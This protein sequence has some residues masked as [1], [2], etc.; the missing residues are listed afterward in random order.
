M[1]S[2]HPLP[3]VETAISDAGTHVV[4]REMGLTHNDF[5]RTFPAV[6]GNHR[7]CRVEDSVVLEEEAGTVVI[8]LGAEGVRRIGG[9]ALPVTRLRIE[10]AGQSKAQIAAFM[11]RFDLAFR[12][13]GG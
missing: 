2:S 11:D 1:Q 3:V 5:F 4:Q 6:A 9:L 12:R 8:Q 13:G 7:W 10:F